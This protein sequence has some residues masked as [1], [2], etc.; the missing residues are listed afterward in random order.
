MINAVFYEKVDCG[1]LLGNI[2]GKEKT[3]NK[4]RFDNPKAFVKTRKKLHKR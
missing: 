3:K 1:K 4:T 2:R